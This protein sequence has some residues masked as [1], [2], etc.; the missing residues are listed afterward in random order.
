M[1]Q[2]LPLILSIL[3]LALVLIGTVRPA[4]GRPHQDVT[5]LASLHLQDSNATA[6][7]NFVA[8]QQGVGVIAEFRDNATPV[9]RFPDG[10]GLSITTGSLTLS[11]GEAIN[12]STDGFVGFTGGL[13]Y[14]TADLTATDG[15]TI[16]PSI[17][18]VY[19]LDSSGAVTVTLAACS[20]DGTPLV[21][22]G[23]DA[24]T[25]TVD[26]VN[27]RTTD[28]N[29][30]TIGQYDVVEWLCVDTEWLHIAKSANS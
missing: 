7:P 18:T 9:A 1:K 5:N 17:Y 8:D 27:I 23:D 13:I 29:A 25:I 21:L 6:V 14:S 26:D 11:N 15:L 4:E 16:T 30:V 3:A 28:G 2:I 22:V 10:G 19:N 12:N 24:N 20:G